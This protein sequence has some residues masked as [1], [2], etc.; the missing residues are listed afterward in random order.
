M[1]LSESGGLGGSVCMCGRLFKMGTV[2]GRVWF[3]SAAAN[4]FQK[5][6]WRWDGPSPPLCGCNIED[7]Q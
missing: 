5:A 1:T 4:I 7:D 6:L 3:A 2:R